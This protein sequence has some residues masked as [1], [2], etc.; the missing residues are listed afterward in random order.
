MAL[1]QKFI[2]STFKDPLCN[3]YSC[4]KTIEKVYRGLF[5]VAGSGWLVAGGGWLVAGGGKKIKNFFFSIFYKFLKKAH[6]T[7]E[8]L[9]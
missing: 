4:R 2:D 7:T 3:P 1:L 6:I 8:F 5:W 9:S